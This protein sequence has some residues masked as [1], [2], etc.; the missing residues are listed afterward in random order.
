MGKMKLK[1]GFGSV[2]KLSG[3]RRRPYIA[4]ITTGW[5]E[6][7]K[8]L[9]DIVGYGES[10]EEA[11]SLLVDYNKD[12][13]D[14][15]LSKMKFCDV[16]EQLIARLETLLKKGLISKKTL[17]RYRSTYPYYEKHH[18]KP[19]LAVS[20]HDIQ[21]IIDNCEHGYS[22]K[23]NIKLLYNKMY[24]FAKDELDIP[25][26]KNVATNLF[27]GVEEKSSMHKPFTD[28]EIRKLWDYK[29]KSF[30][31]KETLIMIY[32]GMRPTEY[33]KIDK[34]NFY[35]DEN[36]L[37][38]GIKTK[39][40]KNRIIPINSNIKSF[41]VEFM[42]NEEI[43]RSYQRFNTRFD[44][45]MR[46]LDM[47]HKPHDC[48]HTFATKMRELNAD[49]LHIKL[50]MGHKIDDITESVYTHI[51]ITDLIKTVNLFEKIC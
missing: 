3:N 25:I 5:N 29:E 12:P 42:D 49:P 31:A 50:I 51:K 30:T 15:D 38:G 28:D 6:E 16:Y 22:T 7:G 4:I 40:G 8:Q 41:L 13:Y 37:K 48:R 14:V 21:L 9:H 1:N 10:Y 26:K 46:E 34:D 35:P 32:E 43:G 44:R 33:L 23:L 19:F 17:S 36:Y 39:A 47:D 11:F 18:N 20:R 45:L 2:Y 27:V 24:D